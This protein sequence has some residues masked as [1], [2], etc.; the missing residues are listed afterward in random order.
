MKTNSIRWTVLILAAWT[1]ATNARA[2]APGGGRGAKR[3]LVSFVE[4]TP[5]SEREKAVRAMGLAVADDLDAVSVTAVESPADGDARAAILALKNPKILTVEEDVY[6]RWL[7]DPP[8]S[9]Q[10]SPLP[11]V[12]D[13]L[14]GLGRL[15]GSALPPGG[16]VPWG[17]ARVDAPKA[18]PTGRGEGVKVAVIDTGVDCGHPDLRC[19]FSSGANFVEPGLRPMDD[20]EHGTHVAGTIAGRGAAGGVL[21]VAPRATLLPVKVL[22]AEGAGRLSD[23]I[24]GILW[25]ADAGADVINMSLGGDIDS[26]AMERAVEAALAAGVVVV[27]AAG[28]SGPDPDTVGYPAGYPGVIAVAASD[29]RDRVALFS[30]RGPAV[31]LI[32]PGVN[33][34]STAPGGGVRTLSGTSMASPHVAGLA[35]LAVQRGAKGPS[36]VRRALIRASSPLPGAAPVED[37]AG[38][39]DAGRLP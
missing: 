24:K 4:G 30:S 15:R 29:N 19:D 32:A 21:G 6:R 13:A 35:A 14:R 11:A 22:D 2:A 18:W 37:G 36:G 23:I 20:N 28:N 26:P 3:L 12:E 33:I 9:L 5:R 34:T 16:R 39:P 1:A 8:A 31:A 25:A 7:L 27:C 38:L 17:V 10:Q